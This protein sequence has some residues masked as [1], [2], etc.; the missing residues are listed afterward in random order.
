MKAAQITDLVIRQ[1]EERKQD[2]IRL[3]YAN[4][5]MVGH[6]GDYIATRLACEVVD[7]QLGRLMKAVKKAGGLLIVTADHGNADD[8]FPKR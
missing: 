3:N 2:F 5:D 7:L 6:T 8:M 4:G 1:I